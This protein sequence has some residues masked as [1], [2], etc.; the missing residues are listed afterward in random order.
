M[1]AR[2]VPVTT[3]AEVILQTSMLDLQS[4]LALAKELEAAGF[5]PV[6]AAQAEALTA[7]A[8]ELER[9]IQIGRTP[10][11]QISLA[12]KN[13]YAAFIRN[14]RADWLRAR[15]AAVEGGE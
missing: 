9:L 6:K 10:Y 15:A 3:M 1:T 8:E 2:E 12:E 11:D 5:G 7:A 13:D 4:S 14:E